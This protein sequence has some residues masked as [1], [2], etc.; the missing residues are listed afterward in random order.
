MPWKGFSRA[1]AD[2]FEKNRGADGRLGERRQ[3]EVDRTVTSQF[4]MLPTSAEVEMLMDAN[5]ARSIGASL[6]HYRASEAARD[7]KAQPAGKA[8]AAGVA[9]AEERLV[10]AQKET[11]AALLETEELLRLRGKVAVVN[12]RAQL[13][14]AEE[15]YDHLL[16]T[17]AGLRQGDPGY[18]DADRMIQAA[19]KRIRDLEAFIE[20]SE[21][22]SRYR[23]IPE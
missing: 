3:S 2:Q 10:E 21:I 18:P 9:A 22:L 17:L 8:A 11:R 12:S 4:E 13:E 16:G 20:G 14:E 19:R 1:A 15:Q 7:A 6:N 5:R 23:S